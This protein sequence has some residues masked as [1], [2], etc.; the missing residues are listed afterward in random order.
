[1]THGRAIGSGIP[2]AVGGGAR[3][4]GGSGAT[5][6]RRAV[7]LAVRWAARWTGEV[8]LAVPV[9]V[10]APGP[11]PEP[12]PAETAFEAHVEQALNIARDMPTLHVVDV[13]EAGRP[14]RR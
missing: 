4:R 13:R 12:T 11:A 2:G 9:A 3:P 6:A 14:V 5:A 10:S 8:A 1:M 7:R